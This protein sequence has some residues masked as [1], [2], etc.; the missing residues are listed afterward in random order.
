M[1][2]GTDSK[3]S[4]NTNQSQTSLLWYNNISWS[5][6]EASNASSQLA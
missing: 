4:K 6:M 2:R 1:I 3:T 5:V